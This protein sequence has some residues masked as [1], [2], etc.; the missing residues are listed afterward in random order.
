M[1]RKIKAMIIIGIIV[2]AVAV[3]YLDTLPLIHY[4]EDVFRGNI[5]VEETEGR[6]VH[7][8]NI[9]KNRPIDRVE[10]EVKQLLSLHCFGKGYVW[11]HYSCEAWDANGDLCYG[12]VCYSRWRVEKINGTWEICDI[13]EKP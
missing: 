9:Q 6:P 5:S 1:R 13:N 8:Y 12:A 7:L 10:V 11:V 4:V 2:L 3:M